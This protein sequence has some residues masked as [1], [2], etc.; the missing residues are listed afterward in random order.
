MGRQVTALA[1][2]YSGEALTG[3][4][5]HWLDTVSV[6]GIPADPDT[7][8][9]A[10]QLLLTVW[11]RLRVTEDLLEIALNAVGRSTL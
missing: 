9:Y 7:A 10:A 3:P 1:S 11:E 5:R 8:R 6:L 4:E 2:P